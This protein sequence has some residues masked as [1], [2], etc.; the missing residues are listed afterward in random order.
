MTLFSGFSFIGEQLRAGRSVEPEYFASV[1]IFFSDIVRFTTLCSPSSPLQVV[2]LLN[3][4]YSLFDPI[5][6]TYEV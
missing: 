3:D 1:T 2:K 4:L 6:K 5:I